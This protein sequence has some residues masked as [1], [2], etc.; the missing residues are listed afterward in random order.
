MPR[1]W[2]NAVPVAC[3]TPQLVVGYDLSYLL[4]NVTMCFNYVLSKIRCRRQQRRATRPAS[5]PGP[6]S[7]GTA[8]A[9]VGHGVTTILKPPRQGSVYADDDD[10]VTIDGFT[11]RHLVQDVTNFKTMLLKLKRVIQEVS[12]PVFA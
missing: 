10:M 7:D 8:T 11:Y 1:E 3:L 12:Q 9:D 4:A 2:I 6:R 5:F